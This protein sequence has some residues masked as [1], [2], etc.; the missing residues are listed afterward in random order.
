[1][2]TPRRLVAGYALTVSWAYPYLVPSSALSATAKQLVVCNT[3]AVVRTF[4][5]A[6]T[7]TTSAP[8]VAQTMFN[9][10]SLQANESKVFGL[11]DVMSS[12]YYIQCKAGE[13]GGGDLVSI[14][15]SG[16]EN[17]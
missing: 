9:A 7:S 6:V 1:M 5:Y 17:T 2:I 13:A 8:T 10:V 15:V 12:G 11:T 14:T 4:Y 16:M 3:D